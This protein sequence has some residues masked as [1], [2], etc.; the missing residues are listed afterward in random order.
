MDKRLKYMERE[1]LCYIYSKDTHQDEDC[2]LYVT[3]KSITKI[4]HNGLFGLEIDNKIVLSPIY[5][6]IDI[7]ACD[8]NGTTKWLIIKQNNKY[9]LM[10]CTKESSD[11]C[12]DIIYDEIIKTNSWNPIILE[13]RR[14][15]FKGIYNLNEGMIF[16][17]IYNYIENTFWGFL[18]H[19]NG[20]KGAYVNRG[21]IYTIPCLYDDIIFNN[22]VF[23]GTDYSYISIVKDNHK[24]IFRYGKEIVPAIYDSVEV[25]SN[26]KYRTSLN[27]KIGL[28]NNEYE[29]CPPVFDEIDYLGKIVKKGILYGLITDD[30]KIIEPQYENI[31]R[32]CFNY[33]A[34]LHLG[35]WG[36]IDN[37]NK[38][39][40]NPQYEDIEAL[41][42]ESKFNNMIL[43]KAKSDNYWGTIDIMNNTIIPF[44]FDYIT[45]SKK[46]IYGRI[47]RNYYLLNKGEEFKSQFFSDYS[48]GY[49]NSN[50]SI[51]DFDKDELDLC[52]N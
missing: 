41:C 38:L 45:T 33:Y 22:D 32:L 17:C 4:F 42:Y 43:F 18:V 29:I 13:L 1:T 7:F 40:I 5:T 35:K 49:D 6:S 46:S 36:I 50:S 31:K 25:L 16:P 37:Y 26:D 15:E 10:K 20:L 23:L 8:C 51:F 12:L 27:G 47:G 39:F 11:L 14:K 21:N 2:K 44:K 3:A 24:G 34:I 52:V 9:G 19:L 48:C 28:Y 30:N